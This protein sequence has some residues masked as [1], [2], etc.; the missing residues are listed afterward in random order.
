MQKGLQ[1]TLTKQ[2]AKE[3]V[4]VRAWNGPRP[5]L[6]LRIVFVVGGFGNFNAR[7]V[8]SETYKNGR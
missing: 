4:L 7:L 3:K 6:G 5:Y 1:E 2:S 8:P